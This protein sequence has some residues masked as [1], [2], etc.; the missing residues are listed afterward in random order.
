MGIVHVVM[1]VHVDIKV[2]Q[3]FLWW[4]SVHHPMKQF[5]NP[6]LLPGVYEP[7]D[8]AWKIVQVG[9]MYGSTFVMH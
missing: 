2:C 8:C 1:N 4:S 9:H 3:E 5:G 6:I 7:Q